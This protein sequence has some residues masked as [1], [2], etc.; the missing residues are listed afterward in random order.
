MSDFITSVGGPM[1]GRPGNGGPGRALSDM[2]AS[3]SAAGGAEQALLAQMLS[4]ASGAPVNAG[5][6]NPQQA[7]RQVRLLDVPAQPTQNDFTGFPSRGVVLQEPYPVIL[8]AQASPVSGAN[9]PSCFNLL[10]AVPQLGAPVV[11]KNENVASLGGQFACVRST[12]G[13]TLYL[14]AGKWWVYYPDDNNIQIAVFDARDPVFALW[15]LQRPGAH[16]NNIHAPDFVFD[17]ATPGDVVL[18]GNR[19]RKWCLIQNTTAPDPT[20]AENR[21][22]RIGF[23]SPPNATKGTQLRPGESWL[24]A[25]E[26]L[27]GTVVQAIR[28][29]GTAAGG[30]TVTVGVMEW[31]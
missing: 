4:S 7:F 6:N 13:G 19:W 30:P 29:Y 5:E 3:A 15:M 11:T 10:Y 27:V 8:Q 25:G 31:I 18:V 23:N 20:L 9:P 24:I 14:P 28:E 21:N 12:N 17:D 16:A 26:T 1:I 22:V 2:I